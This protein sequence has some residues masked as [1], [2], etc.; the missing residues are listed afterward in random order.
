M[1]NSLWDRQ[2]AIWSA[3][4]ISVDFDS[5]MNVVVSRYLPRKPERLPVPEW[6]P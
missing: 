3:L 6:L 2:R 4:P 5:E 1:A